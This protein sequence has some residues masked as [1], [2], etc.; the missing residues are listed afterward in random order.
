M[1]VPVVDV[2]VVWVLVSKWFVDMGVRMGLARRVIRT[3]DMPVVLIV[4]M[5][6]TV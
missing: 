5:P 2:R 6:V 1:C 3:V 4:Y